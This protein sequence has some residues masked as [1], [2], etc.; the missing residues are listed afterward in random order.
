MDYTLLFRKL[1]DEKGLTLDALARLSR[2]HRNTIVNVESGRRVRLKTL[3]QLVQK[4]G[5]PPDSDEMRS[6]LLLYFERITE[7]PFSQPKT[8]QATQKAIANYRSG[9]KQ[10][11]QQL[12][13]AVLEEELP[14]DQIRL[15]SFAVRTRRM[16]E[17]LSIVRSV[18]YD[19]AARESEPELKVAED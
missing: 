11:A 15:L 8:K 5:Y 2:C 9:V 14:E 13:D 7:I 17:V 12:H 19:L 1:R 10:A 4:M 6:V 3:I 16:I 18:A